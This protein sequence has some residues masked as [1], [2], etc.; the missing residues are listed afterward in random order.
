MISQ[1]GKYALRAMVYLAGS[2]NGRYHLVRDIS[3]A[4]DIPA[5]YLSKVLL[6]LARRGLLES[7][8]GRQG[9]FKL[10]IQANEINLYD[11]LDSIENPDWFYNCLIGSAKCDE[12]KPCSLHPLW[13]GVRD[14]YLEF[15]RSTTLDK[16]SGA[17]SVPA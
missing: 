3:Q 6:I 2:M 1:T 5:Q 13:S 11:I 16:L 8:R 10:K 4:L 7:Q 17:G 12:T 9:G 14:R 15:L